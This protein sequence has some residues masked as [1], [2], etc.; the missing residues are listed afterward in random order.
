MLR[1]LAVSA[2][3]ASLDFK[4]ELLPILGVRSCDS[5]SRTQAGYVS[6]EVTARL[7]DQF[8]SGHLESDLRTLLGGSAT[9][10]GAVGLLSGIADPLNSHALSVFAAVGLA[11]GAYPFG[12]ALAQRMGL[13][14]AGFTGPQWPFLY[15]VGKPS[16]ARRREQLQATLDRLGATA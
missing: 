16:S 9:A 1:S 14:K 6:G 10:A 4:I 15:A 13:V 5:L 8:N 7:L 12:Y 3:A 2:A 11:A